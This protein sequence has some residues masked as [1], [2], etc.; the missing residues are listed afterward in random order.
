MSA[1]KTDKKFEEYYFKGWF[2]RA[3]GEFTDK[4][5]ERS[6]N[7]FWAWLKKLNQYVPIKNGDGK[8]ILEVGCSIG[9]VA[10]LLSERKFNVYA[11]DVSQYAIQR[12]EKLSPQVKF[13][14]FDIQKGI[15]IKKKFDIII[16]FEVVEHLEKPE[17][18]IKIMYGSLKSKGVLVM[19][20]PYPYNWIHKDP[21]HINVKYPKDWLDI[22]RRIGFSKV[23]YNRFSLLP[24]FY[25]IHY[26]LQIIMPFAIPVPYINSPIFYI[27]EK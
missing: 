13:L 3:V 6:R 8:D 12:A 25:R 11:S 4:D 20:T 2:K 23:F 16:A 1:I 22:M 27:G 5:L 9:A 10:S 7:W 24:F 19:S 18:A 17:K 21:T 26:R 14:A 15:P